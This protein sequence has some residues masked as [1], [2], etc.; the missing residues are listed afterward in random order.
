LPRVQLLFKRALDLQQAG[1]L[2]LG[3]LREQFPSA[4]QSGDNPTRRL[5]IDRAAS[6]VSEWRRISSI[7]VIH[8]RA[9]PSGLSAREPGGGVY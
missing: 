7:F 8:Q 2:R 3:V 4:V 5:G 6:S 9:F 1:G